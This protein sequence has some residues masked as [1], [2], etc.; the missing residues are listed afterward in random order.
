M[1]EE[2]K[3]PAGAVPLSAVSAR[4]Y[5]PDGKDRL[6][7]PVT[8]L[9][10]FLLVELFCVFWSSVPGLIV[11]VLTAAWYGALF[12]YRGLEGLQTRSGLL[13]FAANCLLALSFAIFSDAWFKY[14]NLLFLPALLM[15]HAFEL[16]GAAK[17]P[18]TLPSMLW[19]RLCL[20]LDGL[21]GRLGA[22]FKA[23]GSLFAARK[24]LVYV[25]AG[26]AA[27]GAALL[28]TVPLLLSADALFRLL[29]GGLVEFLLERLSTW[30]AKLMFAAVLAVFLFSL[31]YA[32]RRPEPLKTAAKPLDLTLDAA[33]PAT[34]L[35]VMDLLY[36]VFTAVQFAALFGGPSYLEKAGISYA[37]YARSGFF[38]LVA[39]A[40][41][42]LT[43]IMACLQVCRREGK[44]WRRV[45]LLATLLVAFSAVMILSAACRMTLYVTRYGLSFKRF[46]TYWG[47]VMLA[48]FLAAALFKIWRKEFSF[49]K[50]LFSAGLAGWLVLNFINVDYLV[51]RYNVDLYRRGASEV[52]DLPY[53]ADLSYAALDVLEELPGE[54]RPY[55]SEDGRGPENTLDALLAARRV[56]AAEEAARWQSW[57]VSAQLAAR[58]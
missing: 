57:S 39:V 27:S 18:W 15:L 7:L 8:L 9:L 54:L 36:L 25:L 4:R 52:M 41:L 55:A 26:L 53:L 29:A 45:R 40:G 28:L 46:L 43:L 58:S 32:L 3:K 37:A 56:Q 38:Q 30:L 10:G 11:P 31:L 19:E 21:F 48:L 17:K 5:E 47:M 14:W 49:F 50:V 2:V 24:R 33:A 23:L 20:T 13:L 12:W 35:V 16:S 42:N 6:L 22:P 34:V 1:Y 51:V 44:G